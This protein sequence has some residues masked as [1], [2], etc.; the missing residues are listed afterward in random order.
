MN[1]RLGAEF[2]MDNIRFRGGYGLQ[3]DPTNN[4]NDRK[5]VTLGLGYKTSDFFIDMAVVNTKFQSLYNPY[6]FESLGLAD[7]LVTSD[8]N[9]TRVSVTAG[10][11][12]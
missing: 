7:P 5:N 3:A 11:N 8:H 10:F 2:R 9:N 12:F 1:Y 4:E 6:T